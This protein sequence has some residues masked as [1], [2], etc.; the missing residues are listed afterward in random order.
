VVEPFS[1][2]LAINFP[3]RPTFLAQVVVPAD[4]TE[5]EAKRLCEMIMTLPLPRSTGEVNEC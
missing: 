1:K 5:T 3:M 2:G 4:M